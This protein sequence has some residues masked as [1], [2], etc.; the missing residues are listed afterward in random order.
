MY[1]GGARLGRL[2]GKSVRRIVKTLM[3][4]LEA[5]QSIGDATSR[6]VKW[7]SQLLV[8]WGGLVCVADGTVRP[9]SASRSWGW[10]CETRPFGV[11]AVSQPLV[12]VDALFPMFTPC[13][14]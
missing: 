2:S 13:N 1:L 3:W 8:Q 10:F 7:F 9:R 4:I 12:T 14:G 5:L 11:T 6:D